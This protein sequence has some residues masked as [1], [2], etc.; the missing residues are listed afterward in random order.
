MKCKVPCCQHHLL[1]HT[2]PVP[3][4]APKPAGERALAQELRGIGLTQSEIPE[5]KKAAMGKAI[6]Y[7]MQVCAC[8][9]RSMQDR[10]VCIGWCMSDSRRSGGKAIN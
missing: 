1:T 10:G 4:P 9:L 2:Y 7:G 5:W 3:T 6:S 8:V